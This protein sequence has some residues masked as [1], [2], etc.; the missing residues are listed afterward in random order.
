MLHSSRT[1]SDAD[2]SDQTS[3]SANPRDGE[4]ATDD[5]QT[6]SEY[7]D[8]DATVS[9]A[10][11][12]GTVTYRERIALPPGSTLHVYLL[13][14]SA[15]DGDAPLLGFYEEFQPQGP[16]F[17]F[18]IIYSPDDIED[19]RAYAV[20][21]QIYD[22]DEEVLFTTD[23]I[24]VVLEGGADDNSELVEVVMVMVGIAASRGRCV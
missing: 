11:L 8:A 20:H 19:D 23:S 15:Q 12:R 18:E 14:I 1:P 10:V 7:S 16:P 4:Q 21:A 6:D 2:E 5:E 22:S 9:A 3:S 17:D 24:Y 13:E